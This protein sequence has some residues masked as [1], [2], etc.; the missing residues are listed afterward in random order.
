MDNKEQLI[1]LLESYGRKLV[2]K[3]EL[4]IEMLYQLFVHNIIPN[5]EIISNENIN[6]LGYFY[7]YYGI[8]YE[9]RNINIDF[10][11]QYYQMAFDKDIHEGLLRRGVLL[12]K[13]KL[14]AQAEQIY[15]EYFNYNKITSI[16]Y[17]GN[18]NFNQ[19]KYNEAIYF[20]NIGLECGDDF[21]ITKLG[22]YYEKNMLHKEAITLYVKACDIGLKFQEKL[23]NLID[24]N[25]H[26]DWACLCQKFLNKKNSEKLNYDLKQ[27]DARQKSIK[28]NINKKN[29]AIC[30]ENSF[31][32]LLPCN[33]EICFNC[34]NKIDK[35]P[36]CRTFFI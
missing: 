3:N 13:K 18:L 31:I 14:Y 9:F 7:F 19:G 20:Y 33:H 12:E 16:R 24:Q 15:E 23:N 6:D 5:I 29:C 27:Y 25:Y 8:Y 30:S 28:K 35:C 11:G 2:V 17:L 10:A 21:C 36:F 22:E 34:C 4:I 1:E 26:F 32:K